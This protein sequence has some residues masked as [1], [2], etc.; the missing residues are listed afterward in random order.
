[1]RSFR[2]TL[3]VAAIGTSVIAGAALL[4]MS[5][6]AAPNPPPPPYLVTFPNFNPKITPQLPGDVDTAIKNTLVGQRLFARVQRLFDLWSWEAFITLN[7]PTNNH[8]QLSPQ[9][10]NTG[11]GAPDWTAWYES[12]G[13]FRNDG[14]VPA[15][16]KPTAKVMALS[17]SRDTT[18]AVAP[19][20]KAFA[21][22]ANFDKRRVRL[23]GNITAV[24][25]RSPNSPVRSGGRLK[26]TDLSDILQA[27]TSP[28]IDQHG[29]FVF[30]EIMLDPNEV[31]YICN[32]KLYNINGQ[33]TF[34][35]NGKVS[36]NL[37]RGIDT[38]NGSGAWEL[39][40]AWRILIPIHGNT[41]DDFSRFLTSSAIVP[42]INGKCP[43]GSALTAGTAS[44][45]AQCHVTV[46]LVGMHIGHKSTTSP[47]WI[48]ATFEQVDNLSVN[49]VTNKNLSASFF[50]A[51]CPICVPDQP[52]ASTGPTSWAN[53][54]P[55]QVWRAIPI[56]ADKVDM[57]LQAST[58]LGKEKS[59]LQFYQLI[60][61]QWP[62]EPNVKP[63]PWTAGLPGA[64]VNKPGGNPTPVFLT[65][66]TM[67]TYFQHGVVS[68]CQQEEL[69]GNVVCP[70]QWLQNKGAGTPPIGDSTSIFVTESCMG[71]HSSAGLYT[72][73]AG[74][75]SGQLTGDF[76]W[77][78]VQKAKLAKK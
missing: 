30:Y 75:T 24:G 2:A 27:F 8:G 12:T 47:Q 28:L 70:G 69:P 16:C 20:L 35:K 38:Q 68:A 52:P 40:L 45:N 21:V 13:I 25:E 11:F 73:L 42:T 72:S 58:A 77:L 57:N 15:A 44:T 22:P 10:G 3:A 64:I 76:S 17:L 7:W 48:W 14:G 31:T 5:S 55:T 59:V 56:P 50:N 29:N 65:N 43:D 41:G 39:K 49:N 36:A 71:C 63:T 26:G 66:I 4:S 46:G 6:H 51:D 54:P 62:T 9:L 61:T 33:V 53:T 34:S 78:F 1:M 60:D 19:D 67:E 18:L 37:P 23:L 32:N 74:D